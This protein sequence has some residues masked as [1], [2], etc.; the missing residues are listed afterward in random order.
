MRASTLLTSAVSALAATTAV[1]AVPSKQQGHVKRFD[2][3]TVHTERSLLP[4]HWAPR[5]APEHATSA[6]D[7]RQAAGFGDLVLPVRINLVQ[8][9]IDKAHDRLMDISHPES[10][11][12]SQHLTPEE[13]ADLF[14]PSDDAVDD[15]LAWLSDAGFEVSRKANYDH[16]KG[17]VTVKM[18]VSHAEDLLKTTYE[19]Y[20]HGPS[21]TP[22][23]AC[24]S[25]SVP[26]SIAHHI[27][28]ITPTTDFD[29]HV[30]NSKK[31][32]RAGP[33]SSL[34]PGDGSHITPKLGADLSSLATH[35]AAGTTTCDSAI[36][37]ACLRAL[38]GINYTPTKNQPNGYG[39]VEY[40]PQSYLPGD[41]DKFFGT[42]AP[43]LVHQRP[44]NTSIDGGVLSFDNNGESD[45]DLEYGMALVGPAQKVNLYQTGDPIIGAS[46]N[47]FLTALDSSYCAGGDPN[48]DPAYPDTQ[49]GGYKGNS[50]GVY[51]NALPKVVSTSYGY[52]EADLSPA[53]EK[54][55]CNEYMK[56]GL[57][58][59]T[60]VFSSG[61]YGVAGNGGLCLDNSGQPSSSG[62]RFNP[63]FP[64]TC[65]YILSVGATEVYPGKK[66]T[67][68][69]GASNK[70]IYSGGGFSNVFSMP[71][72]QST[73]VKNYY[74]NH[75]PSYKAPIY[76]DSQKARG[77]P[78]IS[79]NGV[80][81]A[82]A[83]DGK[84]S[85]I[86]GTSASAPV[87]GAMLTLINNKRFTM[88]KKPIGFI[89]PALYSNPG[90]FH[91]ITYGGNQ[92]CKTKGFTAVSGWDPVTGL[93]TPNFQKLMAYFTKLP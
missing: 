56:L 59:V 51:K 90:M 55:Q 64:S 20:E 85:L 45:L 89:N 49:P 52:N 2:D 13:I 79:A 42:Y 7:R 60:F 36:T 11:N 72:Y 73:A 93:G 48:Q 65:P 5:A 29:I 35:D 66:V 38:Y 67:D 43:S 77:Y 74:K 4:P 12:Y 78:D 63:A 76:N 54:R 18:P 88:G 37:P 3:Y 10:P 46:F 82:V 30:R 33:T 26:S 27:D 19:L 86:Y 69:E 80:N 41:L 44:V 9:N 14:A 81:Y 83:V 40:T 22:H 87:V 61:D 21:G 34:H 15:V 57:M 62:T 31:D 1:L 32:K 47:T 84:F 8:N 53:Y 50:C 17:A 25:Y 68:P 23:I 91:D 16:F 28:F 39:I 92:G 58:G 75:K 71:T 24:S 6:H 70:V